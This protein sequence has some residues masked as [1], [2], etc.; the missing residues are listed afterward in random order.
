MKTLKQDFNGC[1]GDYDDSD[2]K[3]DYNPEYKILQHS[4]VM[5]QGRS[6][7]VPALH[8]NAERETDRHR[9]TDRQT[10]IER[11]FDTERQTYRHTGRRT[12]RQTEM[13]RQSDTK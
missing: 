4:T 3:N 10:D 1:N 6:N 12:D 7:T 8:I 5:H 9:K 2:D 11:Q 13:Q